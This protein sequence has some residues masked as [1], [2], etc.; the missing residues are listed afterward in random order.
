M[1]RVKVNSAKVAWDFMNINVD[2][3]NFITSYYLM[4]IE[5]QIMRAKFE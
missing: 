2:D 4:T 3:W 5:K 1:T